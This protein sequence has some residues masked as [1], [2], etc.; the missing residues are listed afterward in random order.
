MFTPLLEDAL[1]KRSHPGLLQ[2]IYF[3]CAEINGD[4]F[5]LK[6]GK[7]AGEKAMTYAINAI[8]C[9]QEFLLLYYP[10][11]EP[12]GASYDDHVRASVL[13]GG[14]GVQLP[15]GKALCPR[16]FRAMLMGYF[17]LA[18]ACGKILYLSDAAKIVGFWCQSLAYYEAATEL[19]RKY[20]STYYA[21]DGNELRRSM[22]SELT[23]CDEMARLLPEKI[24]QL[25]YNGKAF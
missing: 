24:D 21:A 8:Q 19:A 1:I 25:V 16:E 3:E 5:E 20:A 17:G 10:S 7:D 18:N 6:Q 14:K 9:Y 22:K 4:V 15:P 12:D 11:T 2:E 13:R 23:I